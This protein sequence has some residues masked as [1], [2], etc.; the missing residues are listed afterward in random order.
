VRSTEDIAETLVAMRGG[1]P[2]LV[3]HIAEVRIGPALK[4]GAGAANGRPAV[5]IGIQKQLTANTLGLT[6]FIDAVL[7]DIQTARPAMPCWSCS[8]C[9]WR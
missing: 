2:V 4:L 7:A 6:R 3:K 1:E 5:V 8:S 9:R